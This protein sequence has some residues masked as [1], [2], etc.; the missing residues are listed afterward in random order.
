[1]IPGRASQDPPGAAPRAARLSFRSLRGVALVS[2][3]A[4][5][6]L[7]CGGGTAGTPSPPPPTVAV[8]A[9]ISDLSG[10]NE[11]LAADIQFTTDILDQLFVQLL[12]EQA[13]FTEHPPT[14]APE[15]AL[16]YDWSEDHRGLTFHLREDAVWSDGV[17]ITAEDVR[18]T[19]QAQTSPEIAWTYADMKDAI[20][21]VEVVDAHTVRF[22]FR[23]AYSTQLLDAIEGKILPKHAWEQIPFSAWRQRADWFRDHLVTSGPFV[24][25]AWRPGEEIVLERNERYFD[26]TKPKLDRVV[27]RIAPDAAGH[28]EQLLA[29]TLDFACGI[30]P[31]DA[32]RIAPRQD[33]RVVAFDNRQYDFVCWNTLRPPFDDADIRRA[34]TLAIDRQALVDTLFKTYARVASSPIPSTFW[35]HDPNLRPLPYDPAEARRILAMKG[36][37]DSDG[38]G[39]VER[40]GRPFSF[41]LTTNSSNRNRSAAVVMIQEQLRKV[42]IAATARTIEIHALSDANRKH[43]FDAT[44]SGWAID[45]TLDLT[46]YFHSSESA[47]GYNIGSYQS[48]EADRLLEAARRAETPQAALPDLLRLQQ[49]LHA[50]QP[51]TFLWE[52]QRLCGVR[53]DLIDVQPN[54]ISAYFNLPDWQ[55]R[56]RPDRR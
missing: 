38:D 21:D 51:F 30:T 20:T 43:D 45:T 18:W 32:L 35:A 47:G 46:P 37:S 29:G 16:G 55:R 28:T 19:W 49:V 12:S 15:L 42:G 13:D 31:A 22:H 17:P 26:R 23:E 52:P 40:Q 4:A 7:A 39:I 9:T 41:E 11:L 50:D 1:M 53:A 48:L 10:V 24:L 34:L 2:S 27:F 54:A 25:G 3:L 56:A 6:A 36:F 8:G 33:L 44:I 5:A 14:F